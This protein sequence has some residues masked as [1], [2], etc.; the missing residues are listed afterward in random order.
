M[1]S[2]F[3][4]VDGSSS[5]GDNAQWHRN[6]LLS[7]SAYCEANWMDLQRWMER[8]GEKDFRSFGCEFRPLSTEKKRD[9]RK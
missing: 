8:R 4:I 5:G 1:K 7:L 3:G 9:H 6:V 2:H